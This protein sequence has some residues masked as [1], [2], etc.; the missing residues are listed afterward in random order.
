MCLEG[1]G[2]MLMLLGTNDGPLLGICSRCRPCR[3]DLPLETSLSAC[4]F[5]SLAI[6]KV[7]ILKAI[8]T[9]K[10]PWVTCIIPDRNF[11]PL[12]LLICT[13]TFSDILL[14]VILLHPPPIGQNTA[15]SSIF[16]LNSLQMLSE[17]PKVALY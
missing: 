12:F 5:P 16:L 4:W 1:D 2:Y 8:S 13:D 10:I 15:R 11:I 9:T 6:P 14:T 17:I 3:R 7:I